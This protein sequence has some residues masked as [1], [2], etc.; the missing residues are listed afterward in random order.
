MRGTGKDDLS[1]SQSGGTSA[2]LQQATHGGQHGASLVEA[3]W[4]LHKHTLTG[5]DPMSEKACRR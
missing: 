3:K 4:L 1:P 5:L 2:D